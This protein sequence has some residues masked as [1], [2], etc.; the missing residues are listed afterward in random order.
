M[1]GQQKPLR[2]NP[3]TGGY[4]NF[5]GD[6]ILWLNYTESTGYISQIQKSSS[7]VFSINNKGE[8]TLTSQASPTEP[9]LKIEGR[10]ADAAI[11]NLYD[12]AVGDDLLTLSK[13]VSGSAFAADL[14]INS[15]N[16]ADAEAL[17]V[18]HDVASDTPLGKLLSL[19]YTD[20]TPTWTEQFYFTPDGAL[21]LNDVGNADILWTN[22]GGGSIGADGATRPANVFAELMVVAGVA[23][24]IKDNYLNIGPDTADGNRQINALQSGT[25]DSDSP[26]I[27]YNQSSTQWELKQ[28]GGGSFVK[29]TTGDGNDLDQAYEAFGGAGQVNVE[30]GSL[31]WQC[32]S[33]YDFY[34]RSANSRWFFADSSLDNL[35]LET[36]SN[37]N[38]AGNIDIRAKGNYGNV[39]LAAEGAFAGNITFDAA[40]GI[41]GTA[42]SGIL[43]SAGSNSSFSTSSGYLTI[44]SATGLLTLEGANVDINADGST[45]SIALTCST[46]HTSANITFAAHGSGDIPFNSDVGGQTTLATSAQNIVGAINEIN[47][48]GAIT[49]DDIYDND[50]SLTIDGNPLTFSQTSTTGVGFTVTRALSAANTDS[51]LV[52]IYNAPSDAIDDQPALQSYYQDVFGMASGTI[53]V[54]QA[55]FESAVG[56]TGGYVKLYSAAFAPDGTD[57]GG[58]VYGFH[59]DGSVTGDWTTYGFYSDDGW[60]YGVYSL[61]KSYFKDTTSGSTSLVVVDSIPTASAAMSGG[62]VIAYLAQIVPHASDTSGADYYG[63]YAL[64]STVGSAIKHGLYADDEWDYGIYSLSPG[65]IARTDLTGADNGFSVIATSAGLGGGGNEANLINLSFTEDASD[66]DVVNGVKITYTTAG[67]ANTTKAFNVDDNWDYGFYS[68]SRTYTKLE[69]VSSASNIYDAVATTSTLSNTLVGYNFSVTES[70]TDSAAIYGAYFALTPNGSASNTKRG[71]YVDGNWDHGFYSSSPN[72]VD[73]DSVS[74]SVDASTVDIASA[75]MSSTLIKGVKV[76]YAG[77]ASD[78]ATAVIYGFSAESD[79]TGSATKEAFYADGNWT[80]G[81]YSLSPG[82]FG[83]VVDVDLN[84][85]TSSV[86]AV[87]ADIASGG[88]SSVQLK[89]VKSIFAGHASDIATAEVRGFSAE[90]DTTGSATKEAFY[91]DANWT[92]SL[93]GLSRAYV[94]S[95]AANGVGSTGHWSVYSSVSPTTN[96]APNDEVSAYTANITDSASD[97]GA[98]YYGLYVKTTDN[99]PASKRGIY[100]DT[101]W[102]A[103]HYATWINSGLHYW[104]ED[105]GTVTGNTDYLNLNLSGLLNSTNEGR[106][107]N[108]NITPD[109]SQADSSRWIAVR[110]NMSNGNA[111]DAIGSIAFQA[112]DNW[113][114]GLYIDNDLSKQQAYGTVRIDSTSS[115][116]ITTATTYYGVYQ[117][118]TRHASDTNGLL[119]CFYVQTDSQSGSLNVQAFVAGDSCNAGVYSEAETSAFIRQSGDWTS[120]AAAVLNAAN[121]DSSNNQAALYVSA[122]ATGSSGKCLEINHSYDGG[123]TEDTKRAIIFSSAQTNLRMVNIAAAQP[124]RSGDA[125]GADYYLVGDSTYLYWTGTS[126]DNNLYLTFPINLPHGATVVGYRIRSYGGGGTA[127]GTNLPMGVLYRKPHLST[128]YTTLNTA[129]AP[130]TGTDWINSGTISVAVDNTSYMYGIRFRNVATGATAAASVYG[131]EVTYE[132]TDFAAACGW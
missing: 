127:T 65:Y 86:D 50:Q 1:S 10:P 69:D 101:A 96:L 79:S 75:G 126:I 85:I 117:Y 99:G 109:S 42:G 28:T 38:G 71:V 37:S 45:G 15:T 7:D 48:G 44:N 5:Q 94:A 3:S 81:I 19:G 54:S 105:F 113:H 120:S 61:S 112:N 124:D 128:T 25:G 27:R 34:I 67:G 76:D 111:N 35:Y 119:N 68:E 36:T 83:D 29:I 115:S 62:N 116:A 22:D 60:D 125:S 12:A 123:N 9:A 80:H 52:Q 63:F 89:G 56:V 17:R 73:L 87:T 20:G 108:L 84:G 97:G 43:F 46:I 49:W 31:T 59:A 21:Y 114:Y 110:A 13:T 23:T 8:V 6:D 122:A 33:P 107:I 104:G 91:A 72:Y 98:F 131:V 102:P 82:Y 93:Y 66:A 121:N 51:P 39:D 74:A 129:Y 118:H 106:C 57:T 18:T 100:F 132:I 11:L 64:G 53:T 90:T 16:H 92:H 2:F 4:A 30:A 55:G 78:I 24:T 47:S 88:S 58:T 77:H 32:T 41:Q 103:D 14:I 95:S 130:S 26:A 40:V 70:A